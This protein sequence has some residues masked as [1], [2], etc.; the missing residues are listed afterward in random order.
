MF[1]T[2]S[3]VASHNGYPSHLIKLFLCEKRGGTLKRE[4]LWACKTPEILL[5]QLK[6]TNEPLAELRSGAL[7]HFQSDVLSGEQNVFTWGNLCIAAIKISVLPLS[8]LWTV[9]CIFCT[10]K[11]WFGSANKVVCGWVII[12]VILQIL[13]DIISLEPGRFS[14]QNARVNNQLKI[15]ICNPNVAVRILWN[16]EYQENNRGMLLAFYLTACYLFSGMKGSRLCMSCM[17]CRLVMC[18]QSSKL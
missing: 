3:F 12:V 4:A 5:V 18:R 16:Q 1:R 7:A 8:L 11:F 15:P 9:K 14:V 13:I 17:F 6:R 2:G 10:Y